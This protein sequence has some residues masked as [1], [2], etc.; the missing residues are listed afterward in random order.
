MF[1]FPFIKQRQLPSYKTLEL[2]AKMLE[3]QSEL[4]SSL[5]A[6]IEDLE[7]ENK[8]LYSLLAPSEKVNGN[9][10]VP[11][12]NII[13]RPR[14]RTMSEVSQKLEA[15]SINKL[16]QPKSVEDLDRNAKSIS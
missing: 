5:K 11:E 6:R 14:I 4:V 16:K 13:Y 3:T 12:P 10:N 8:F 2:E 1:K 15:L 7:R 9:L